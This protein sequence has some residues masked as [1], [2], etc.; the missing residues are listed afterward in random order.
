MANTLQHQIDLYAKYAARE[1]AKS[2]FLSSLK[3]KHD[4][5]WS[6]KK[7]GEQIDFTIP[8]KYEVNDTL[9]ISS[10]IQDIEHTTIPLK[11]DTLANVPVQLSM[12]ELLLDFDE[13]NQTSQDIIKPASDSIVEYM[14]TTLMA[15]AYKKAKHN[16]NIATPG[17]DITAVSDITTAGAKLSNYGAPKAG[18]KFV[19]NPDSMGSFVNANTGLFAPQTAIGKQYLEGEV[20]RA[21]KFDWM[22]S[23]CNPQ[24]TVGAHGGTPLV[25]G[26]TQSGT[27]LVTDGW[28]AS[29]LVLKAGDVFTVANVKD[30]ATKAGSTNVTLSS[31]YQYTAAADVTSDGSGNAT[32]TLNESVSATAGKLQN[33][34]ALPADNAAITVIG[35][36]STAYRQNLVYVPKAIAFATGS[37]A[38]PSKAEFAGKGTYGGITVTIVRD[39][40]I[41]TAQFITRMDC[42]AGIAVPYP[43]YV[44]RIWTP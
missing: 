17:T 19:I 41:K 5:K 42:L 11:L 6:G 34:D 21:I 40:D 4:E 30:V 35:T 27:S 29:T 8:P 16:F 23:E 3:P 22:E 43:E 28:S 38:I 14:E 31:S 13:N 7:K 25:N 1:I 26:A 44:G 9:D 12:Q 33:V 2:P 24:H 36:A 10:A 15:A 18:R 39:Y 20:T 32:I 37:L